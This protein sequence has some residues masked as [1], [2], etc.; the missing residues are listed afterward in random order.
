MTI[1]RYAKE[2]K[3]RLEEEGIDVSS[4]APLDREQTEVLAQVIRD[5]LSTAEPEDEFPRSGAV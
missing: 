4:S 2:L 3:K 5:L 1:D